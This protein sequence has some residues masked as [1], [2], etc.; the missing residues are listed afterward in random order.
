MHT[1]RTASLPAREEV[2]VDAEDGRTAAGVPFPELA[3]EPMT[4][5]ALDGGRSFQHRRAHPD[6]FVPGP[7]TVE[8]FAPDSGSTVNRA[9]PAESLR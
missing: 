9:V 5:V 6:V 1:T 4:E 7:P 2:F 3:G 8:A